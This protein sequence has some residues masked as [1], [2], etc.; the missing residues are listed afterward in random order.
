M[1]GLYL[2]LAE[3]GS[4]LEFAMIT[5]ERRLESGVVVTTTIEA[6]MAIDMVSEPARAHGLGGSLKLMEPRPLTEAELALEAQHAVPS[7]A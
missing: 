1:R 3:Q 6:G 4:H 2:S 7:W 5:I